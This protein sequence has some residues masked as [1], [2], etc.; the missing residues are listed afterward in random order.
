MN[1]RTLFLVALLAAA[2]AGALAGTVLAEPHPA[3]I[4]AE[5]DRIAVVSE[6]SSAVLAIIDR[7]GRGG[8]V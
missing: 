8:V 5:S 7:S 6:A 4:Q 1:S 3:V 2:Q